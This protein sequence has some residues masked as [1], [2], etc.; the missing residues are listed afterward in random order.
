[1]TLHRVGTEVNEF[2][3]YAILF[4]LGFKESAH[5]KDV[6]AIGRITRYTGALGLERLGVSLF[7]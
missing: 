2:R 3:L 1:L 5:A 6:M 4:Q 7:E